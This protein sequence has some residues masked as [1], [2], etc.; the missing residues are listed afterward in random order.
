MKLT[1]RETQVA[2]LI[3]AG[4]THAQIAAELGI[5]PTTVKVFSHRIRLVLNAP[6]HIPLVNLPH[7][8]IRRIIENTT[9]SRIFWPPSAS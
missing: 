5:A 4:W 8:E 7:A 6:R 2:E 1:P 9:E 3:L